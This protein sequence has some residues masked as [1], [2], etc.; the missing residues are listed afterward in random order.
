MDTETTT[1]VSKKK[2]IIIVP[3]VLVVTVITLGVMYYTQSL[4]GGY[5]E[6]INDDG[7]VTCQYYFGDCPPGSNGTCD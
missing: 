1:R 4:P 7:E 6:F 5:C 2:W 3:I